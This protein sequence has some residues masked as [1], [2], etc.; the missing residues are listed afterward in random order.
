MVETNSLRSGINLIPKDTSKPEPVR[1]AVYYGL[2]ATR[3][4]VIVVGVILVALIGYRYFI[5]TQLAATNEQI[6]DDLA[7]IRAEEQFTRNFEEFKTY[8]QVLGATHST[9]EPQ[10]GIFSELEELT[11]KQ[12]QLTSFALN[13]GTVRVGAVTTSYPAISDYVTTLTDSDL[14]KLVN[15]ISIN[16]RVDGEE[17]DGIVFTLEIK[18]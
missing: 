18:K 2:L 5:Q 16:R 17:D 12:I 15:I 14:A 3:Y 11:P 9:L 4:A 10:V 1:K 13:E 7:F 8:S 6:Q